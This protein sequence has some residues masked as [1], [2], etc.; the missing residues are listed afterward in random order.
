M[1]ISEYVPAVDW[2]RRY[3]RIDLAGDLIASVIVTIMLIPQSLAYALLAN[4]PPEVGLYASILPLMAY[5]LC[6]SSRT[7]AVGPVAVVSLMTASAIGGIAS[8]GTPEYWAA[9]MLLALLSGLFLL[10]LGLLRL[11]FLANLLSHPVI[12]GFISASA[13]LIALSQ[14][15][16]ILGIRVSGEGLAEVLLQIAEQIPAVNWVTAAIGMASLVFLFWVRWSLAGMLCRFGL[17]KGAADLVTKAGPVVAVIATTAL[18]S[19]LDLHRVAEVK[20]VGDIPAGLPPLTVPSLDPQLWVDLAPAATLI[21]VVGFVESIAVAQSLAAKRR[22]KIDPDQELV[23][24]G[25]ANLAAAFSGGYPVTGGFARSVVNFAAGA[26]TQLAAVLTAVFIAAATLLLTPAFYYLPQAVLAATIIVAVLGLVDTKTLN[27]A[28]RYNKADAVSLLVTALVVL[29]FGVEAGIVAG[30]GISLALY[31]WRT[32]RPHMAVVGQVPGTEHYRNI[33]RHSV[34]TS[35][36][37]LMVRV[38]ESLYFVNARYLEDRIAALV[39]DHPQAQH[40]V[41]ICSAVNFIDASALESLETIQRNLA[42]AGVK[43]H[44][45][46]VKG[47]VMDRL[48]RVGFTE[49]LGGQVFLSTHEA[50]QILAGK[51]PTETGGVRPLRGL[52]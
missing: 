31:V 4:L 14:A 41:L 9:A 32:S 28:W 37:V 3:R 17:S 50:M 38:D 18:V 6:G 24:L 20:I 25:V 21:A 1:S 15:K 26:N 33:L 40:V 7:L 22:Q 23:G 13:I 16:H 27:D 48:M 44:L 45:A 5:A 39:A 35:P 29:G 46:E 2:L 8:P 49:H 19:A 34:V 52:V 36:D 51:E 30:V 12:S 43:L 47:P 42:E 11:G 10:G